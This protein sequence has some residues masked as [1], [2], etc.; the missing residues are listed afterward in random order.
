MCRSSVCNTNMHEWVQNCPKAK[1]ASLSAILASTQ[2][3]SSA[4]LNFLV[5]VRIMNGILSEGC[6]CALCLTNK[7]EG[8]IFN[9]YK[10]WKQSSRKKISDREKER[11]KNPARYFDIIN[12][13]YWGSC[14]KF[15]LE[16]FLQIMPA[17][18]LVGKTGMYTTE[19]GH[20]DIRERRKSL[21][22]PCV[23]Q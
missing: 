16:Q 20:W 5:P 4:A 23:L 21:R 12:C 15:K 22:T 9:H 10:N 8:G 14:G 11:K 2:T 19:E 7:K 18:R 13:S 17:E 3:R 6:R 1:H